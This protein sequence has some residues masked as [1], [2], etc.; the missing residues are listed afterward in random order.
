MSASPLL[1][2]PGAKAA[3]VCGILAIVF[4]LTC[5]GIPVALVLGI[6]ALVQHAKAKRLAA[7]QPGAY[8]PVPATGLVTGI[9]GLA[10]PVFLVPVV[11]IASAIAIPAL[12]GQR[13]RARDKA[14]VFNLQAA[15]SDLVVEYD[16]L[17][18]AGTPREAIP[19][20]LE[21]FLRNRGAQDHSPWAPT[22][23]AVEPTLFQM[24]GADPGA[25][26]QAAEARAVEPGVAIFVIALPDP[27]AHRD[28]W[29]A[30]ASRFKEPMNGRMVATKVVAL[31]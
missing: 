24:E 20:A 5:I 31:D 3:K 14:V 1:P 12:L 16:R 26:T 4:A 29:L 8:A 11:G 13:G 25:L 6:V 10:L 23:P 21:A 18:A 28:G 27:A 30:G 9:I 17:V 19:G 2:A 7:A 15:T 22:R